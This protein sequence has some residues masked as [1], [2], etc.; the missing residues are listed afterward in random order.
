LNCDTSENGGRSLH[1]S[2]CSSQPE[3]SQSGNKQCFFSR[4][5]MVLDLRFESKLNKI[6]TLKQFAKYLH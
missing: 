5:F 3:P 1:K 4:K 2:V 6:K